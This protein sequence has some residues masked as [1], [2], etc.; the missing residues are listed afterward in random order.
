MFRGA[1]SARGRCPSILDATQRGPRLENRNFQG[2]ADSFR[3]FSNKPSPIAGN[4]SGLGIHAQVEEEFATKSSAHRLVAFSGD[5]ASIFHHAALPR[6][7][8]S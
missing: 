7:P 8:P 2:V 1:S 3:S 4:L 5:N 6:V